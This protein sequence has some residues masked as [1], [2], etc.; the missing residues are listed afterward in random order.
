MRRTA[1]VLLLT[2]IA[3]CAWCRAAI[4]PGSFLTADS[5]LLRPNHSSMRIAPGRLSFWSD[6]NAVTFELEVDRPGLY[7]LLVSAWGTSCE[8]QF[9]IMKLAAQ[10][11]GI[12]GWVVGGE[13][14]LYASTALELSAGVHTFSLHFTNDLN[15]ETED[16]NLFVD[17]IFFGQ[18]AAADRLPD[19]PSQA[20]KLKIEPP[21]EREPEKI[22]QRV[23][24][25]YSEILGKEMRFSVYYPADFE[26]QKRYPVLYLLHGYAGKESGNE[27]SFN[28]KGIVPKALESCS[29]FVVVPDGGVSWFL[30][31]P[32]TDSKY[33]SYF[34]RELLPFIDEKF[35]TLPDRQ[36]RGICGVSMGGHGALTLAFKNPELFGS[37][38]SLSGILDILRHQNQWNL[39]QLLGPLETNR[40]VW[41][42]NSALQLSR[43][44]AGTP[45]IALFIDCGLNDYALQENRDFHRT[46][47]ELKIPH[48][49]AENPG[50]HTMEYWYDDGHL[51]EHLA[52]HNKMFQRNLVLS[53]WPALA[54]GKGYRVDKQKVVAVD[55]RPYATTGFAD[56]IDG[57]RQG[58][59]TD[60]GRNDMRM[61]PAG[62]REFAGVPLQIIDPAHNGGRSCIVLAGADRDYFPDKIE[63]IAV[64][65][66]FRLLFFLHALA[67]GSGKAAGHYRINYADQT[68]ET[69]ILRDGVNIG[70]WWAPRHLPEALLAYVA[71]NPTGHEVGLWL[72]AWENPKP[73]VPI[74]S[75]DFV[76]Y[77]ESVPILVAVS[78]E[79]AAD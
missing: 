61:L 60:Q 52:F 7:K 34:I 65:E 70:D 35:P 71:E 21:V 32:Y 20:A 74:A 51:A 49:Y 72:F 33:E 50:G 31:S 2:V 67:W 47:Q 78:G 19:L 75:I 77:G 23:F 63:G 59:W 53:L 45:P 5:E 12:C 48:L 18:V 13:K 28:Y 41:E 44:W 15:S 62:R 11:Q 56:E 46:L 55:L 29:M 58:G 76:S 40:A 30:D 4:K 37:A 39:A 25:L 24:S 3:I 27:N 66:K 26:P 42:A 54:T 1:K 17:G 22:R 38:S 8:G 79:K 16:R 6:N 57:D 43:Q 64:G 14:S 69:I 68:S 10:D 73:E 9:P 36:H